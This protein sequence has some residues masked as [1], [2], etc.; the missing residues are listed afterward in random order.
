MPARSRL[1]L[2]PRVLLSTSDSTL[3]KEIAAALK[4]QACEVMLAADCHQT[5]S[6]IQAGDVDVLVLDLEIDPREFSQLPSEFRLA[7]LGCRTLVL[8]RSLEQ[9]ILATEAQAHG[10]LMKPLDPNQLGRVIHNLLPGRGPEVTDE[11]ESPST[12]PVVE[13]L[14]SL[15]RSRIHE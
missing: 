9:A 6:R 3:E 5:L 14:P 7:D 12:I 1:S 2:S 8:A 15:R 13:G 11:R 10:V 4:S